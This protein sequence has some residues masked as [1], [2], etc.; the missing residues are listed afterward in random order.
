MRIAFVSLF[1][2]LSLSAYAESLPLF[3]GKTFAGWEG[4]IGSVWR[5]EDGALVAGSF[6]KKQEKNNFL[7]TTKHARVTPQR[8]QEV[9]VAHA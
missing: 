8:W 2:A 4:D 6:E 3:D 1:L 5:V 9:L 7:A